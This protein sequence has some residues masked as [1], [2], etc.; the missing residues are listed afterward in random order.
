M[1]GDLIE[2]GDVVVLDVCKE[3]RDWGYNPGPDG[4]RAEVVSFGEIDYGRGSSFGRKPGIYVNRCW[5]DIRFLEGDKKGEVVCL[6]TFHLAPEDLEK[7]ERLTKERQERF[8]RLREQG[9]ESGFTADKEFLRELPD[10]LFYERDLV[11]FIGGHWEGKAGYICKIDYKEMEATRDDGSP[12]PF[13]NVQ[14]DEGGMVSAEER[15]ISLVERGNI[16]KEFHGETVVFESLEEEA[17][18]HKMMGRAREIRNPKDDLYSFT[19]DEALDAIAAGL[20]HAI[21]VGSGLFG[22]DM[23]TSVHRFDDEELGSRIASETLK[24]FDR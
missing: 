3:N 7:Y 4:T 14:L 18:Y 12:W 17:A 20:G 2:V 24:G 6:G 11:R 8:T 5:L 19:K 15:H 21:A 10:T 9:D 22:G 16:W 1:N 13:Y 23:R